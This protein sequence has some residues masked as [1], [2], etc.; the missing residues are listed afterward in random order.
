MY[1]EA[2][3]YLRC[4]TCPDMRL[5]LEPDA[6]VQ[7]DGDV[8]HGD[9]TCQRCNRRYPIRAGVVD[10]L[11]RSALPDSPAQITNYL[12]PT[13]WAYER[14]WRPQAL[15]L[16]TGESFGYQREL[17]IIT[18]LVAPEQGG[19]FVDVACSTGLY[20]RAI[21][22]HLDSQHGHVIAIDHAPPMLRQAH[23]FAQRE[24]LRISFVRA[25]A[26][27]L[28]FVAGSVM[29]VTMGGSLNEIG[30]AETCLREIRRVLAPAGR[31]ALM[32]LVE[33]AGATGRTVQRFL[34]L[35][36]IDF[37]PLDRLNEHLAA[38]GFRLASQW[39]YRVVVFSLLLPR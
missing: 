25:K 18:G 29:G 3:D 31:F 27:A 12:P 39:Q 5:H 17:P 20:A 33:A 13:A 14:T 36:G 6:S 32:N 9:L 30:D 22:R 24:G 15:T 1:P 34:N 16:L 4:P 2:L 10:L 11:G 19:L 7:P 35:G 37:W 28:P 21:A 8:V 38:C 26:Q 23:T